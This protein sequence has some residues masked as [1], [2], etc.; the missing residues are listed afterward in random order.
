MSRQQD[1]VNSLTTTT[2]P[3]SLQR[4]AE[5]NTD[6]TVL[7]IG[8]AARGAQSDDISAWTIFYFTYNASLQEETKTTAFDSWDR[9]A[10]ANYA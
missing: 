3:S 10:V 8:Y 2:A 7:Y 5:Y 4:R 9:R 6:G 1:L